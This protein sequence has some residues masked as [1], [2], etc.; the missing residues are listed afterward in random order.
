MSLSETLDLSESRT[1]DAALEII[2]GYKLTGNFSRDLQIVLKD[3]DVADKVTFE[4][5]PKSMLSDC[6][7]VEFR[8]NDNAEMAR[9]KFNEIMRA[10]KEP[11]R[12]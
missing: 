11:D 2:G 6:R 9:S 10:H 5:K 12:T 8:L 4:I 1:Y 3:F 7:H